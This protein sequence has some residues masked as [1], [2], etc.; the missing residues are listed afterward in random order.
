MT[1]ESADLLHLLQPFLAALAAVLSR[2]I[3]FLCR[4]AHTRTATCLECLLGAHNW[5]S[6]N[7]Q[8]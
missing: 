4:T 5:R 1:L 7:V 3:A 6:D 2:S 8:I